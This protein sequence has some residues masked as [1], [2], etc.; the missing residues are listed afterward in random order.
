MEG[1]FAL[2]DVNGCTLDI[3]NLE[4]KES[5]LIGNNTATGSTIFSL[6]KYVISCKLFYVIT[7]IRFFMS[8]KRVCLPL[9]EVYRLMFPNALQFG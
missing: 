4:A 2:C 5:F 6:F 3:H 8:F 1:F 9:S 7:Y